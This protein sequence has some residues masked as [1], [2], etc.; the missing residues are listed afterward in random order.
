MSLSLYLV[1]NSESWSLGLPLSP[2]GT[3][4]RALTFMQKSTEFL[5]TDT[6]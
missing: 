1:E 4:F 2:A 6:K 5:L 3:L